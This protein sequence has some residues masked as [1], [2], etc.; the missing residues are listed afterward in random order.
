MFDDSTLYLQ[1][2]SDNDNIVLHSN[3][4]TVSVQFRVLVRF[5]KF[6]QLSANLL[7]WQRLERLGGSGVVALSI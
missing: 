4:A 3:S 1:E 2:Q 6:R 7:Y 5:P